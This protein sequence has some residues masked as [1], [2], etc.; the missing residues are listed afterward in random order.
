MK[1]RYI[2]LVAFLLLSA[3][4]DEKSIKVHS[5]HF[6]YLWQQNIASDLNDPLWQYEYAY[7]ASASLMV[8]MH[9]A[10]TFPTRFSKDP[11]PGFDNFFLEASRNTQFDS[12]IGTVTKSQF[13][14]FVTQ[15]LKLKAKSGDL[16][17]ESPVLHWALDEILF[18]WQVKKAFHWDKSLELIGTK[19]RINWILEQHPVQKSYYH[20]II[21]EDWFT[22][23]ALN[24]LKYVFNN[25]S[26]V[27]PFDGDEVLD[28]SYRLIN[29][30]GAF[31]GKSWHFQRGVW[32][33]HPDYWYVG[34]Y[35]IADDLQPIP[36]PDIGIDSSHMHRLALWLDSFIEG[37]QHLR[38]SF[39]AAK[40]GFKFAFENLVLE[41]SVNGGYVLLQNNFVT[42]ENGVY[43]YNYETQGT[44]SGYGPYQL[45]G[46]LFIGYYVFL[47]SPLYE[48]G[49]G[50]MKGEF[51]LSESSLVYYIGPNTTRERHPL[52]KWPDY[53]EN[54]FAEIFTRVVACYN[55][56]IASCDS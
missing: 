26:L 36:N 37:D 5:E 2:L 34:H 25:L 45:S 13:L 56:P 52:F 9:Y 51:P 55:A 3:C 18:T 49:M 27:L 16:T 35:E 21:D 32:S 42:G 53:F 40:E 12:Y 50:L 38:E 54:G 1:L 15:Y 47:N 14:Y 44:G 17:T 33:E 29:E 24:D 23:A 46:T 48:A 6:T 8:P 7:D 10:F 11:R 30:L 28:I 31:S 43:R 22:I 41:Q 4:G 19:G 39:I 20:A